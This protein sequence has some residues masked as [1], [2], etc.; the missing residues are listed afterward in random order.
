ML[1]EKDIAI[2]EKFKY[3]LAQYDVEEEM[4]NA[5]CLEFQRNKSKYATS[6]LY[7]LWNASPQ[8]YFAR[9]RRKRKGRMDFTE[10][11]WLQKHISLEDPTFENPFPTFSFRDHYR[12]NRS[13]F[14]AIVNKCMSCSQYAGSI[15]HG[16][17][18][19]EI[20]IATVFWRFSNSHYGYRIAE[21]TLGVSARFFHNF[22]ERFLD[23]MMTISRSI[24]VWPIDDPEKAANIANGFKNK[25]RNVRL[26]QAIGAIDGKIFVIQKSTRRGNDYVDRKGRASV[27][28]MAV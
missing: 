4:F 8:I 27:N 19:V 12:I 23:A 15:L 17:T 22:T 24:I 10:Q 11:Y 21:M 5:L 28:M 13:T 6:V 9:K 2:V 18:P 14:D 16:E 7:E 3:E 20:Q 1:E 25:G 26:D